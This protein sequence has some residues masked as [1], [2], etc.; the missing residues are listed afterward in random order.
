M[1]MHESSEYKI[2]V[3]LVYTSRSSPFNFVQHHILHCSFVSCQHPAPDS[4]CTRSP[5]HSLFN[6]IDFAPHSGYEYK[7]H[8]IYSDIST[9]NESHGFFFPHYNVIVILA[10]AVRIVIVT[11]A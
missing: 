4:L 9:S 3:Y 5:N 2:Q 8:C 6:R 1:M 11:L 10:F 7:F